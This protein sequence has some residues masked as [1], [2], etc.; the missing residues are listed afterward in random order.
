MIFREVL[1]VR[2]IDQLLAFFLDCPVAGHLLRVVDNDDGREMPRMARITEPQLYS[3]NK[4][5]LKQ[6]TEAERLVA[7]CL[8]IPGSL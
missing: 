4:V 2:R 5:I 1:L 6:K 3:P 8:T 7:R